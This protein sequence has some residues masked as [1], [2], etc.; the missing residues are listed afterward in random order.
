MSCKR[1]MLSAERTF[2]AISAGMVATIPE[3]PGN[4]SDSSAAATIS[5]S[6][7]DEENKRSMSIFGG[8][9]K[10]NLTV[11]SRFTPS[12]SISVSTK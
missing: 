2:S 3:M 5:G 1:M 12:C 8:P 7:P 11:D 4:I 6:M 10:L 9:G